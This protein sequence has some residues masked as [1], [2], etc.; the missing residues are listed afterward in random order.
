MSQFCLRLS[1]I[2]HYKFSKS[3]LGWDFSPISL[4]STRKI[5]KWLKL[6]PR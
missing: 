2:L 4:S 1:G 5:Q 3:R 6:R